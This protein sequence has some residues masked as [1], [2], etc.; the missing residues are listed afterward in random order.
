MHSAIT[1]FGRARQLA[2]ASRE[3]HRL[4]PRTE[5]RRVRSLG[6]APRYERAIGAWAV[7]LPTID[8]VIVRRSARALERY[9]PDFGYGHYAAVKR[10]PMVIGGAAGVAG[11]FAAAQVPPLRKALLDRISPGEGPSAER[12]E[13]S[14]FKVDF[15]GEGGGRR[16]HTRVSGGD[17]GYSETSKMLAE[18]GL[19]LARDDLPQRAGQLTPAA[20][21]GGRLTERLQR[22]G[23]AFEVLE[24]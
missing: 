7:P 12:R 3:R 22:A 5:G 14:W 19:C 23:I 20:A 9:G 21:M 13:R 1:A 4:E 11:L 2:Q 6:R 24:G 18:S 15:I 8:P 10:L 16:V 17:P